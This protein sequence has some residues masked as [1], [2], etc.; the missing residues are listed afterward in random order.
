MESLL[1]KP[2]D[3]RASLDAV[4]IQGVEIRSPRLLEEYE[5]MLGRP[6][7]SIEASSTTAPVGH[8]NNQIHFYDEC[9]LYLLEHHFTRLI[10]GIHIVFDPARSVQSPECAFTGTLEVGG[11][12]LN[13]DSTFRDLLRNDA[14]AYTTHF[15][16]GVYAEGPNV[17]IDMSTR[18]RRSTKNRQR[19]NTIATVALQFHGGY[20]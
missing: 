19:K 17:T 12:I 8:R 9:G 3:V 7:R 16:D 13:A 15:K 1:S 6:S 10:L 4:W 18:D 2:I 14:I 11:I 20:R 5:P